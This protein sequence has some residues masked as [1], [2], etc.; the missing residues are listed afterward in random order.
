[1]TII[2]AKVI[3]DSITVWGERLTTLVLEY[4]REFMH[5]E[6][7]T[8][9]TL[10]RSVASSRAIPIS[11]MIKRVWANPAVP[12]KWG[13]NQSG[14][15]AYEEIS[16]LRQKLAKAVWMT[17]CVFALGFGWLL[18]KLGLHKQI[19][20]RVYEPFIHVQVVVTATNWDNL[21]GL[22]AHE[23]AEPHFQVLAY[24]ILEALNGST[25][26]LLQEGEWHLPFILDEELEQY[27]VEDLL[28]F[29]SARCARVSY[30]LPDGSKANPEKDLETYKK[31]V[32]D[33]PIHA[34]PTEHQGQA[35]PKGTRSGNFVGWVQYRKTLPD[36]CI[37]EDPRLKRHAAA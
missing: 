22:R 11:K 31:L 13:K 35:A 30:L 36:E 5:E 2:S 7:L 9:R 32:I 8:H 15:Q 17:A 23:A 4:P 24:K 26:K 1:M 29:S 25:P 27:S 20:N 21:I 19:V 18:S 10:S 12:I 28:K 14:M 34:S 33:K 16:P 6:F 37:H 3:A